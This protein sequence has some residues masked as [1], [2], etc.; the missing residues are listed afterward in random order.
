MPRREGNLLGQMSRFGKSI[1]R[2]CAIKYMQYDKPGLSPPG[3]VK[4]EEQQY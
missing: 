4:M 2:P 1:L 3:A